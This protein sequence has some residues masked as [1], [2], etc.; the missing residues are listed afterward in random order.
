MARALAAQALGPQP[1]PLQPT[2]LRAAAALQESQPAAQRVPFEP[3]AAAQ[4]AA[5]GAAEQA[6][7]ALEPRAR[8]L[9][10]LKLVERWCAAEQ[11]PAALP[12]ERQAAAI[13][14]G[15]TLS[16]LGFQGEAQ[17][18]FERAAEHL[19]S[20]PAACSAWLEAGH[21]ARRRGDFGLALEFYERVQAAAAQH[22]EGPNLAAW[23]RFWAARVEGEMGHHAAA[24]R[25]WQAL[26]DA[27]LEPGLRIAAFDE[28]ALLAVRRG[29]GEGAAGW[30]AAARSA[31]AAQAAAHGA[32]GRRV[33]RALAGMRAIP[34][35][36]LLLEARQH[37]FDDGHPDPLTESQLRFQVQEED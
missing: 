31:L 18:A 3:T 15:E 9:A 29:D 25:R 12:H 37:G 1:E 7:P 20:A 34:E 26:A 11:H 5:A 6:L 30:I 2:A 14:A 35:L 19:S 10:R 23:A 13:G 27:A 17:G 36:G 32:E 24:A 4:L 16:A 22:P 33:R 21:C 8:L 28:L